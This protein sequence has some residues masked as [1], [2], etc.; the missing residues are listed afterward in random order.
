MTSF[1]RQL[2][3][4]D[5]LLRVIEDA[6]ALMGIR[7]SN[8]PDLSFPAFTADVLRLEVIENTGLHL[9]CAW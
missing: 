1:E 2:T 4:F 7:S 9:A 6:S 5:D 8:N 3:G